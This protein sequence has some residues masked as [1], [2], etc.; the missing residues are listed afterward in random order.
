MTTDKD[1]NLTEDANTNNN[2]DISVTDRIMTLAAKL[3][4][5][6]LTFANAVIRKE[7]QRKA[8]LLAGYDKNQ[9]WESIDASASAL[10]R[11]PKVN[12]YIMA[13][14]RE[15]VIQSG[16]DTA[17]HMAD[18]DDERENARK[19]G[20][21]TSSLRAVELKGK[22]AGV[23]T[24]NIVVEHHVTDDSEELAALTPEEATRKYK[25]MLN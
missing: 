1:P 18:L 17:Q 20:N 23:Y 6:H 11:L 12:A 5:Q 21:S 2:G 9:S 22:A 24:E 13:V 10:L 19:L 25:A 16:Y 3:S 8:Y 14:K 15:M 7:S 4:F